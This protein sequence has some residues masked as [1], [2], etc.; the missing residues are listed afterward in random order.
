MYLNYLRVIE[1]LELN[2]IQA[3]PYKGPLIASELYGGIEC[4]AYND[5]DLFLETN[6]IQ[7]AISLL[8][9]AGYKLLTNIDT[10]SLSSY[11][12]A[13]SELSLEAPNGVT[14]ELHWK[15]F[16]DF[17]QFANTKNSSLLPLKEYKLA[18]REIF[19][20]SP[21]DLLCTLMLHGAKHLWSS[22]IWILDLALLIEHS[23]NID[24]NYVREKMLGL[25]AIHVFEIS[26]FL[27]FTLLKISTIYTPS[28]LSSAHFELCQSIC[29]QYEITNIGSLTIRDS[30]FCKMKLIS[31]A[32][33]KL[34][35]LF[36]LLFKPRLPDLYLC[37]LSKKLYPL[38]YITR[39]FRIIYTYSLKF[40]KNTA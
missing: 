39:P 1:L 15:R 31:S 13:E 21:E 34:E 10:H 18:D 24:L 7:K 19:S 36:R 35:Y 4:R 28:S 5:L 30:F 20:F 17:E 2:K 37:Q 33:A 25:N 8:E 3:I 29:K 6:D 40:A 9:E 12:K 14:V 27:C 11:L 32:K 26:L 38:G 23:N 16:Y 22:P